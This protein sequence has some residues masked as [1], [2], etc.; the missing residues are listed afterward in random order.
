M[1]PTIQRIRNFIRTIEWDPT[2][3]LQFSLL[4]LALVMLFGTIGY[5]L[6]EG[7]SLLDSLYMTSITLTTVGFGE[8]TPLSPTGRGFTILL[9]AT[10][11]TLAAYAARNAAEI[12]FSQ[13]WWNTLGERRMQDRLESLE[14]HF[15]VCGYGR[16]GQEISQEFLRRDRD[17]VV[18]DQSD[19]T[20]EELANLRIPYVIADATT[21]EA[22]LQAGI[23][24]ACGLLAVVNS[25]AEN[26]L[27]VLSAKELNPNVTVV[28]RA[29]NREMESKLVRAGADHVTS[30]YV[31]GGQRMAFALVRP[32][33][34]D[35]LETVVYSEELHIEMGQVTIH[36]GSALENKTL[37]ESGLREKWGASIVAIVSPDGETFISPGPNHRLSQGDVMIVVVPTHNLP[38]LEALGR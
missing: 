16:V 38:H 9:L 4:L 34:Y 25:D 29:A 23:M 3:Q 11:L 37:S 17:F 26:V 8:V 36:P 28:A 1:T 27:I 7:M 30:P 14:N 5:H 20:R 10:G 12:V 32:A 33:V 35:F 13:R 18:I 19:E 6:I 15:I 22:L 31:I 2:Q 24:R 21:D